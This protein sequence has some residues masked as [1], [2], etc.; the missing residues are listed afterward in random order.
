MRIGEAAV[1][2][3]TASHVLRHWE[4]EGLLRPGRTAGGDRVYDTETLTRARLIVLCRRAQL[5]LAEIRDLFGAP[6]DRRAEQ[7]AAK[8]AELAERISRLTTADRF[9][10]H[11]LECRHP[12]VNDCPECSAFA[13]DTDADGRAQATWP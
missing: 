7:V 10:A 6:A 5:S 9:L 4:D 3:G 8:R 13:N 12:A 2:L 11:T 1:R